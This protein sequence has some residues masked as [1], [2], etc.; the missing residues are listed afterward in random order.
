MEK[1]QP[2]GLPFPVISASPVVTIFL[3]L[4]LL[5][6]RY[7]VN[8]LRKSDTN[9]VYKSHRFTLIKKSVVTCVIRGY[10]SFVTVHGLFVF[11]AE[12]F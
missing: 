6:N 1:K 4:R 5:R 7:T 2:P 12:I 11:S 9:N 3:F 8:K 10:S